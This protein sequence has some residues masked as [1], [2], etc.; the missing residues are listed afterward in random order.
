MSL[1]KKLQRREG[2]AADRHSQGP[3]RTRKGFPLELVPQA[4]PMPLIGLHCSRVLRVTPSHSDMNRG[5]LTVCGIRI[6]QSGL[7]WSVL[8]RMVIV[9]WWTQI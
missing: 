1:C 3:L 7:P 9:T 6:S 4:F 8:G 2:V 5:D